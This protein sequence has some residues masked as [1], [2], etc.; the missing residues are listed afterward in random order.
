MQD[1]EIMV[2]S[3]PRLYT[4]DEAATYLRMSKVTLWRERS[5]GRLK[6]RRCAGRLVYTQQDLEAYLETCAVIRPT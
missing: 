4:D 2:T 5:R 3:L 6:Y 1:T